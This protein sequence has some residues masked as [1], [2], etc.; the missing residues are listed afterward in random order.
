[1][2]YQ[3]EIPPNTGN[4][5]RLCACSGCQLHLIHPMGFQLDDSKLKRA[6]LDYWPYLK[7]QEHQDWHAARQA[8]GQHGR[9]FAFSTKSS[10]NLWQAEF[11]K[12]DVLVFGPETRGLPPSL[13]AQMHSLRI[14]MRADAPVRSLN[15]SSAV[16][17]A[18]YEAM[19]QI[20]D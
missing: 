3:P 5:A 7:V 18:T 1:V 12:G 17:I 4:V 9:W 15:L 11:Q 16:S 10:T 6:G 8:L 13:Q 19:R 14:P 2:L 20:S